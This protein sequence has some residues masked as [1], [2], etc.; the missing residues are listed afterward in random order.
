MMDDWEDEPET[1]PVF[2]P[3]TRDV[4]EE[5]NRKIF[6]QKLLAKKREDKKKKNIAVSAKE[7]QQIWIR[8]PYRDD[9]DF[10]YMAGIRRRCSGEEAVRGG[11]RRRG[12][13]RTKRAKH[14]TGT[15][16]DA[17]RGGA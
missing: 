4:M 3:F 9:D 5:I 2:R 6:E 1:V 10:F 14:K 15:R 17:C 7:P 11:Q 13:D 12:G 16:F 8:E